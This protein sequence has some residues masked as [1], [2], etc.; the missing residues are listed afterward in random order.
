MLAAIAS[1]FAGA[2]TP[3][4]AATP[5]PVVWIG[6]PLSAHWP[7]DPSSQPAN[8]HLP[9]GGDWSVDLTNVGVGT[10]VQLFAAPQNTALSISAKVEAVGPACA[11]GNLADGGQKVVVGLYNG[12]TKIGNVTYAHVNA[13]LGAGA[14]INRWN[15]QIG[16]VGSYNW[17][18]CWQGVHL[19]V[20]MYNQANY[21]CYNRGWT[22]GRQVDPTNFLGFLGGSYASAR[23]QP[24]P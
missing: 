11:S 15:T 21:S 4:A 23:R 1:V 19:H 14:W 20:E 5:T 8:H 13:T 24:C 7:T 12:G 6:S 16:V 9:Y 22:G 2:S 18:S 3:A 10:G 17:S